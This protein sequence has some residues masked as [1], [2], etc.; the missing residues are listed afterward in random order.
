MAVDSD[1]G[2]WVAIALTAGQ[3]D[4]GIAALQE[5]GRIVLGGLAAWSAA[6]LTLAKLTLFIG[7]GAEQAEVDRDGIAIDCPAARNQ[8]VTSLGVDHVSYL[9][10]TT[11]H[12]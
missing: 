1:D 2:D 5:A 7:V 12:C 3:L 8:R 6:G 9:Q 4:P 11:D 10:F